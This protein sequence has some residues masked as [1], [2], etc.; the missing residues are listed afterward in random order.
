MVKSIYQ[1]YVIKLKFK[2]YLYVYI[3]YIFN[4]HDPNRI[5][6]PF[7]IFCQHMLSTVQNNN[8]ESRKFL[9]LSGSSA[10]VPMSRSIF[11]FRRRSGSLQTKPLLTT[12][13]RC[14]IA[15]GKS[16]WGKKVTELAFMLVC[17]NWFNNRLC[18][19]IVMNLS[20]VT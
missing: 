11:S 13:S 2:W 8:I 19:K 6:P 12:W 10:A 15:H 4:T 9:S 3:Q 7:Y 17:F 1:V 18:L 5:S 20:D 16:C 14:K